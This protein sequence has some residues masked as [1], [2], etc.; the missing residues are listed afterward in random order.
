MLGK[1]R[2]AWV[3]RLLVVDALVVLASFVVAYELRV[4]LNSLKYYLRMLEQL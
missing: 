2:A 3:L 4:L 1:R